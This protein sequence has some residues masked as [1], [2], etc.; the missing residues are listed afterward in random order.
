VIAHLSHFSTP[1]AVSPFRIVASTPTSA[2]LLCGF[3]YLVKMIAI[4]QTS[5]LLVAWAQCLSATA[6]DDY[7]WRADSNYGWVD[8]VSFFQWFALPLIYSTLTVIW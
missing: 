8:M 4:L 7:V 2:V 1:R 3:S 5:L 6:L